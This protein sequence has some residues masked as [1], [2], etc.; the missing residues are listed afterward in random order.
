MEEVCCDFKYSGA[1][2]GF[3]ASGA[4]GTLALVAL[5]PCPWEA[6]VPALGCVGLLALHARRALGEVSGLRLDC[7]RAIAVRCRGGQWRAGA[8]RDGCFVAPWLTIVR[9]RPE[10]ARRDRTL[11]ILPG[12]LSPEAMRKIRVILKWS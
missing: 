11:L 10:G 6:A 4:A 7:A 8:V 3:V 2:R 1:A 5:T 12:M 9:W